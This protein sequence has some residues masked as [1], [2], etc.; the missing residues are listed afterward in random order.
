M[1]QLGGAVAER[2]DRAAGYVEEHDAA[3]ILGDARSY[4]DRHPFQM[5]VGTAVAGFLVGRT[6]APGKKHEK[7]WQERMNEWRRESAL[8]AASAFEQGRETATAAFEQGRQAATVAF[9]QGRSTA[10]DAVDQGRER[11]KKSRRG[12]APLWKRAVRLGR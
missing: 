1:A 5:L 7:S 8:L 10:A 6:I 2:V 12:R 4:P 9:E 11:W 3:E